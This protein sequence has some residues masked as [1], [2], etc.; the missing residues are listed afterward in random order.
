MICVLMA[1]SAIPPPGNRWRATYEADLVTY[2]F[3]GG[4]GLL[5]GIGLACASSQSA[6][7]SSSS[8]ALC[9]ASSPPS[10]SH[11]PP[12][13]VHKRERKCFVWG[14]VRWL[15]G[16]NAAT[17][18]FP[19]PLPFSNVQLI[20]FGPSFGGTLRL[21]ARIDILFY[22]SKC[23]FPSPSIPKTVVVLES[24]DALWSSSTA[25]GFKPLALPQ[26][27]TDPVVQV[28]CSADKVCIARLPGLP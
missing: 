14:D 28:A 7:S 22:L 18:Y 27:K 15:Q 10:S 25:A 4:L 26:S 8:A 20:A 12:R 16:P 21:Y 19:I 17:P 24:G 2:L 11:P 13:T 6:A 1:P 23:L 3:L 9:E 5:G